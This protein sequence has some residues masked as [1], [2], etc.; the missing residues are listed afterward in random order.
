M[1]IFASFAGF[2]LIE[3]RGYIHSVIGL[4]IILMSLVVLEVIKLPLPQVITKIP[5]SGP[6]II[7]IAFALISSPCAS[8][9][10]F[11]IIAMA[12]TSGSTLGGALIM[13]SYSVGYT[14][15]IFL[16]GFFAGFLKQLEFFKKHNKIIV[17]ISSVILVVIGIFYL[18]SGISWFLE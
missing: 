11:A 6:F 15:L 14:G 13:I 3:Y 18:Y 4:F 1:G 10:L 12:A 16:T 17:N 5:Q 8:P 9:I 2:V 7:G